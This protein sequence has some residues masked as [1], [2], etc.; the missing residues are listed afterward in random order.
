[1]EVVSTVEERQEAPWIRRIP[2]RLIEVDDPI[3]LTAEPN[4]VVDRLARRLSILAEVTGALERRHR[5]A[6]ELD[7]PLVRA[8][9]QLANA[10][11]Q[12]ICGDPLVRIE[13][14]LADVVDA[15]EQG[16]VSHTLLDQDVAVEARKGI[17]PRT[18][19]KDS[20]AADAG[21]NTAIVW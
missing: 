14:V 5:S 9:N 4:P 18:V 2:H 6:D 8:G 13:A 11:H 17:G 15:L 10:D 21:F 12:L 19:A 20:I 1:M 7:V 16:D 3:H